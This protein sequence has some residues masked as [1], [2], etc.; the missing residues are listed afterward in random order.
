MQRTSSWVI[1]RSLA[2]RAGNSAV[3][4]IPVLLITAVAMLVFLSAALNP[5]ARTSAGDDARF[6]RLAAFVGEKMKAYGVP[7]VAVGVVERGKITTR[8]FG[9]CSIDNPLPV[10][11]ET[12]FQLGSISKTYT[13]TLIMQLVDSG[14]LRLDAPVRNYIPDF[15]VQDER[16]S[17]E[18]TILTLLTHLGGWEGDYFD[19]TGG[20]DDALRLLEECRDSNRLRHSTRAGLTTMRDITSPA[21]SSRLLLEKHTSRR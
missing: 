6:D 8:G 2:I 20:G 21:G 18:A 15:R 4:L 5:P 9:I 10:T 16:A 13:G 14:K 7:G 19:D 3:A 12:L 11:D 1:F 17:N